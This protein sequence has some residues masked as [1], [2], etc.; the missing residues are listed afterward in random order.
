MGVTMAQPPSTSAAAEPTDEPQSPM[1]PGTWGLPPDLTGLD[2]AQL[3]GVVQAIHE[4]DIEHLQ[5][6][7]TRSSSAELLSFAR[8]GIQVH[9]TGA[10]QD[11]TDLA[12]MQIT[13]TVSTISQQVLSHWQ[14]DQADLQGVPPADFDRVFI[15][16]HVVRDTR[17]LA[18]LDAALDRVRSPELKGHLQSDRV[19]LA[20]HLREAQRVQMTL[21]PR[22]Q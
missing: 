21:R 3:A 5:L 15:D 11:D 9:R 12:R 18:L 14:H 10:G 20:G 4:A 2:D 19:V 13:P 1:I 17:A 6:A 8:D 7:L 22:F 16:H